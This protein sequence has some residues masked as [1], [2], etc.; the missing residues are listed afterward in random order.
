[1]FRDVIGH[2]LADRA[3]GESVVTNL[4]RQV[5]EGMVSPQALE[6]LQDYAFGSGVIWNPHAV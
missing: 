4:H 6:I 2:Q 3:V 1:L 5:C